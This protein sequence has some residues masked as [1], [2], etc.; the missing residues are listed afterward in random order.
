MPQ[1]KTFMKKRPVAVT[2]VAILFILAGIVGIAYHV[3]EFSQPDINRTGL[4]WVLIVRI[5][6]V[7][8]GV[9]LLAGIKWARWLAVAWL[10]YHV[11]LSSLHS[12]SE[13]IM[14][15]VLMIIICVLLFHPKSSAY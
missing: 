2:I 14:H 8:S 7:V 6:A 10:L 3:T 11:V 4:V 13:T 15:S 5:L 1:N 9:L 12:V